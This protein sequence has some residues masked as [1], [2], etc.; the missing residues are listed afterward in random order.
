MPKLRQHIEWYDVLWQG[1]CDEID[2]FGRAVPEKMGSTIKMPDSAWV[3]SHQLRTYEVGC[4][5]IIG[6]KD[7]AKVPVS[8]V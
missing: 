2:A 5:G 3:E 4:D 1:L 6:E 7:L 8:A